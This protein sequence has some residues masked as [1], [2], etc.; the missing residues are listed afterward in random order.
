[1]TASMSGCG[2]KE[3]ET[4]EDYG[5]GAAIAA[6]EVS[7]EV[8]GESVPEEASEDGSNI[9]VQNEE[10]N[11]QNEFNVGS[12]K[13]SIDITSEPLTEYAFPSFS[14]EKVSET[15][16][17]AEEY[18]K[19]LFGDTAV[20]L[21]E[22]PKSNE[23]VV[24]WDED[25]EAGKG[26]NYDYM[27]AFKEYA[28]SE[29]KDESNKV[30]YSYQG[31]Y[32]GVDYYLVVSFNREN[33]MAEMKMFPVN[34]GDL[35]EDA[36]LG[37]V[38][39]YDPAY[40][41]I[42]EGAY[43]IGSMYMFPRHVGYILENGELLAMDA[44]NGAALDIRK[45]MKENPNK[46]SLTN[47]QLRN[48][49]LE[50]LENDLGMGVEGTYIYPNSS[51]LFYYFPDLED[52]KSD[53]E[54]SEE[55]ESEKDDKANNIELV[56][57]THNNFPEIDYNTSVRDGYR[58]KV[59]GIFF[60][61]TDTDGFGASLCEGNIDISS[62][63][64]VGFDYIWKYGNTKIISDET[65]ILNFENLMQ[66]FEYEISDSTE[67]ANTLTSNLKFRDFRMEYVAVQSSDNSDE[68]GFVPSWVFDGYNNDGN[69]AYAAYIN[70]IDGTLVLEEAK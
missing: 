61:D 12:V 57:S 68:Y 70:A 18:A 67:I 8:Q 46:C 56:F 69:Y 24:V 44:A 63:G 55:N 7:E 50:F 11:Y 60:K 2:N 59:Q 15:N 34:P 51:D 42:P 31:K 39:T 14:A 30:T 26:E 45:N 37:Y 41:N 29:D 10:Y 66:S 64:I 21:D 9:T 32:E 27:E 65:S 22:T 17:N 1:M 40:F 58:V 62:K 13:V 28:F 25:L 3:I 35:C 47:E 16:F 33:G 36:S 19:K 4:V 53:E 38:S 54:L 48:H 43:D 6:T 49:A 52:D 23:N 5:N 20:Q